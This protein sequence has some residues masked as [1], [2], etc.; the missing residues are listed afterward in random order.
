MGAGLEAIT[1]SG[2]TIR[3]GCYRV[4]ITA[5]V[6]VH[7]SVSVDNAPLRSTLVRTGRAIAFHLEPALAEPHNPPLWTPAFSGVTI[8]GVPTNSKCDC[9]VRTGFEH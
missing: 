5:V 7:S 1:H 9:P 6:T 3:A 8:D 2:D 4:V